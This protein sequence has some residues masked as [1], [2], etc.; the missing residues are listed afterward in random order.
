MSP[1]RQS[2]RTS[3]APIPNAVPREH[4]PTPLAQVLDALDAET[5]AF[6]AVHRLIDTVEVLVKL[7]TVVLVSAFADALA[8]QSPELLPLV[9][10]LLAEGLR[11]PSLGLWW[12]FARNTGVS[13]AAEKLAEPSPGFFAAVG[14]GSALFKAIEGNG[15]LVTFRNGYAHGATPDDDAC[16]TDLA[17]V[18]A[19]VRALC[20]EARALGAASFVAIDRDGRARLLRGSTPQPCDAPA[21]CEPGHVYLL[22]DGAASLDL[23]PLLLWIDGP[24]GD[25]A[26]FYNDLKKNDA[27]A[28]HY[29]WAQHTRSKSIAADLLRRFPLDSWRGVSLEAAEEHAIL[30][31]I[32]ALTER[33]KGRRAELAKIVASL[34]ARSRGVLLLWGAPGVGKSALLARVLQYLEWQETVQRE[35]YPN[36]EPPSARGSEDEGVGSSRLELALVRFFVRR[37]AY[38]DVREIFETLGRQ[39][40]RRFRLSTPGAAT[41]A[42]SARLLGERIRAAAAQLH[43]NQRLVLVI[44]GL[45]EA[46]EHADFLRGLPKEAPDKVHLVYA[47]R[48][49]PVVRSEV[50]DV[51]DPRLRSEIELGGLGRDD[52]RA[53]L[54]EHVDKYAMQDAWVNAVVARSG[55]NALYLRLLCDS[56]DR[57]EVAFNDVVRLPTSMADLYAT[58]LRR[59]SATSGAASMLALMAAA[60]AYLPEGLLAELLSLEFPDFRSEHA[61]AAV[62]ACAE[63]LMD[64]TATPERDWQLFHE[65]L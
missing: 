7:H 49:Q 2:P 1:S 52:T 5:Q 45:D 21:G 19:R 48:P 25:G 46:A 50:Y 9:R 57:G 28:L 18:G 38:A 42:E 8:T 24:R 29:A 36:L 11:T 15:N 22:R 53:L 32:A 14:P 27:G 62:E 23:H 55:G 4:L 17:S 16:A 47:S 59:V 60:H 30:E 64:D 26:Y 44:D 61:R 37:G 13:L 51:I 33:F 39:L 10:K 34:G 41:A 20:D 40:D 3:L 12:A 54:Y 56:L 63:V 6:R 58:V 43:E 65:S 35:A 31:R